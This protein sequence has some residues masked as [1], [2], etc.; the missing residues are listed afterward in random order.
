MELKYTVQI[1]GEGPSPL[2]YEGQPLR[3][4]DVRK[5]LGPTPVVITEVTKQPAYDE[6]GLAKGERRTEAL[7]S[8]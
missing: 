8:S 1:A 4:G 3:V 6:P 2:I 7:R 5:D